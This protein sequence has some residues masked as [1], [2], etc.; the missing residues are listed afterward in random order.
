MLLSSRAFL[1]GVVG[2][3]AGAIAV[4]SGHADCAWPLAAKKRR[5]VAIYGGAFDPPTNGHLT[6]CAELVHGR[7][8]DGDCPPTDPDCDAFE[9]RRGDGCPPPPEWKRGGPEPARSRPA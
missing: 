7:A 4:G 8:V 1:R 6:A 5:R 2:A 9:A 3:S